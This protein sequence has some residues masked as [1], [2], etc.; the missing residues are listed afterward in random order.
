MRGMKEETMLR[1]TGKCE[2]GR[3]RKREKKMGK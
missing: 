3:G 1:R 2:K